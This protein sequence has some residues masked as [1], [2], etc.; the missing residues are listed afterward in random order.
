MPEKSSISAH[1]ATAQYTNRASFSAPPATGTKLRE[2]EREEEL[3]LV[4]VLSLSLC[5]FSCI[6]YLPSACCSFES[7]LEI[8]FLFKRDRS[9]PNILET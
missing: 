2:R 3:E 9:S 6:S 8:A 5:I 1:I 7:V 4:V